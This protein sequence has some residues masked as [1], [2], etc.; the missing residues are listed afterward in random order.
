MAS[1]VLNRGHS[2]S[3]ETGAAQDAT[4]RFRK[5]LLETS[6]AQSIVYSIRTRVPN[7][8]VPLFQLYSRRDLGPMLGCGYEWKV[9]LPS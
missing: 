5:Y 2:S 7:M 9:Y 6:R 8:S 1:P 3:T 4:W